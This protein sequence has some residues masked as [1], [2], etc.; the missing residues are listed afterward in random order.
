M[1]FPTTGLSNNQVHKEGNRAFVYDSTL[2]VWDQV[3]ESDR[4][5]NKIVS[6][7]VD[8]KSLGSGVTFPANS[9]VQVATE[10]YGGGALAI[11]QT[12]TIVPQITL[13]FKPKSSSNKIM[14]QLWLNGIYTTQGGAGLRTGI[15]WSVNRWDSSDTLGTSQYL[16]AYVNYG[17]GAR[18]EHALLTTPILPMPSTAAIIEFRIYCQMNSGTMNINQDGPGNDTTGMICWE[19]QA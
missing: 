10:M 3:K 1:A 13:K 18:K 11:G 17:D 7:T 5:E 15:K 6:G 8:M 4:T 2:G 9:V 19:I 14:F 12:F 16:G